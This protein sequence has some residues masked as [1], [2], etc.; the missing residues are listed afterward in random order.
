VNWESQSDTISVGSVCCFH[1]SR[2]NMIA[3]SGAIV[4]SFS[5]RMKCA[6]LVNRSMITQS[7]LQFIDSGSS[8]IKSIA[9]NCH[10]AYGSSSMEDS[11]YP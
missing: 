3:R 4:F 2:A 11:P 6:I 8:T 7:W 9:I 10:G 1:T 5:S